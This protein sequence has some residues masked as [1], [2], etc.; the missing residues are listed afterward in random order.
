[1]VARSDGVLLQRNLAIAGAQLARLAVQKLDARSYLAFSNALGILKFLSEH[2]LR[3]ERAAL[4]IDN[5]L[6]YNPLL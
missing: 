3:A 4:G 1:M 2:E 5:S 6:I